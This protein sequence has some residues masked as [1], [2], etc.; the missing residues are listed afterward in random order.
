MDD[1]IQNQKTFK[2]KKSLHY[3]VILVTLIPVVY[4]LTVFPRLPELVPTH[5]GLDGKANDWSSKNGF[6]A[7]TIGLSLFT[8]MIYFIVC[9]AWRIDPKKMAVDNIGR[10]QKIGFAVVI[11]MAT[12]NVWIIYSALKGNTEKGPGFIYTGVGIL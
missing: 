10:M 4:L 1:A 9:N 3:I 2:M 11:F 6:I 5:F 12:V 7:L 8:A